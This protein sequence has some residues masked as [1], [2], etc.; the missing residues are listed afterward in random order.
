MDLA[1]FRALILDQRLLVLLDFWQQAR[2]S[3]VMPDWRDFKPEFFGAALPHCWVWQT[4]AA[5]ELRLRIV[6]EAVMQTMELNLKGKT[7]YELYDP[8][9]AALLARRLQ[10]V[11]H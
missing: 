6:G 4:D 7:P 3:R 11:M 10:R 5:G 8:D 2:G 9:Q 1:K